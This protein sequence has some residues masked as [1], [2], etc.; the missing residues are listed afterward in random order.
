MSRELRPVVVTNSS[1][2]KA[3]GT[4]IFVAPDLQ[5][6]LVGEGFEG[7]T[8]DRLET[9]QAFRGFKAPD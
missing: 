8:F 2:G 4:T 3:S 7:V 6:H 1:F 9:G 5:E